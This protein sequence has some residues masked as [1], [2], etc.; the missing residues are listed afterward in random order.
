[1]GSTTQVG[2]SS[3]PVAQCDS[4]PM[5]LDTRL[6]RSDG[7]MVLV[8]RIF[9]TYSFVYHTFNGFISLGDKVYR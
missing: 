9:L 6:A 3:R 8:T 5:N 4:S 2:E 1:M 7:F